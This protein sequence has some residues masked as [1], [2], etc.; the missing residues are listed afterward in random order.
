MTRQEADD[1]IKG[2]RAKLEAWTLCI[3]GFSDQDSDDLYRQLE[4]GQDELANIALAFP[5]K[6][7]SVDMLINSRSRN[8]A[9]WAT[10]RLPPRPATGGKA[11]PAADEPPEK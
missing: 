11:G 6:G 10:E 3:S 5:E 8:W 7:Y 9:G 4:E 1:F 2:Y